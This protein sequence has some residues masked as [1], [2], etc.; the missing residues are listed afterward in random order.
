MAKKKIALAAAAGSAEDDFVGGAPDA[1]PLKEKLTRINFDVPN[2]T[3]MKFKMLALQ[4][5]TTIKQLLIDFIESEI[6]KNA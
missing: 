4:R 6:A 5:G 2:G 3:H 1:K